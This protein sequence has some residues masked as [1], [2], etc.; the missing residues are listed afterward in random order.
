MKV[1][2]MGYFYWYLKNKNALSAKVSNWVNIMV[3]LACLHSI[4]VNVF[5]L[6]VIL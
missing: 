1:W 3:K 5:F 6:N 4:P 2:E